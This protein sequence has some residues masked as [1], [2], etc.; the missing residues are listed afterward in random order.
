MKRVP[1]IAANWK[2][3]KTRDEALAYIFQ[4]NQK[5]LKRD[6]VESIVCAPAILLNL[7]VK[8]EGEEIRIAA[9]NMHH[10]DEGAFTGENSPLQVKTAGA[11]YILIGHSER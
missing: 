5:V 6:L 1:I 8:R 9:Q 2:M 10:L 3:Y 7:M 11:E 4:V